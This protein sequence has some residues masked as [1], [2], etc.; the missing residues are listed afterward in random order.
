MAESKKRQGKT[1][2]RLVV[3]SFEGWKEGKAGVRL[4]RNMCKRKKFVD[5]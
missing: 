2:A 1:S 4:S 5:A 3:R